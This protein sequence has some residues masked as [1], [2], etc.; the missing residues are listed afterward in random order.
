MEHYNMNLTLKV[1]RQKNSE[2]KGNFENYQVSEIS[3]EM[4]FLEMFDVLNERLINEGKDPVAFDHDCR[5]GICGMCS[6]HI[7]GRAHGPWQGTTTCQLHMRAFKDGDTITVEPWRAGAFP[8]VKDLTVHRAA[9]DRIIEAGGFV[10]VNTGNAQDANN[11][12]VP[13]DDAD[14]AF[15]AAA[16]IGCGACVAACK[17]SSAM[18]FVSAKVSQLALLPQGQPEKKS[19]VL[20]MLAQM[21]KEGF[22]SCTNTGACE[23]ECP[24][25]ISL[26]NIARLNREFIG[27]G[28]TY[29]K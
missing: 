28:F 19:R 11:I 7:N 17:N 24:K 9:F 2:A 13:K 12:P 5:E 27:A 23:A 20:N 21:D 14:A 22:G 25:E 1:W 8:V 10:S 15:A 29:E 6:M 18:L 4:S 16:C 3:S 26:T